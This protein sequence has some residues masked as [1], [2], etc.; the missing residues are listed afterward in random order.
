MSFCA[1]YSL[2]SFP[3]PSDVVQRP[4]PQAVRLRRS[5]SRGAAPGSGPAK[6]VPV[7]LREGGRS[8]GA[9]G[10]STMDGD[11]RVETSVIR[12]T[13]LSTD[14]R[15]ADLHDLFNPFGQIQ[16]VYLARDNQTH[17]ARGF[18]FVHFYKREDAERA[19]KGLEG[20]RYDH[21]VLHLEWA[22]YVVFILF[23]Y[24]FVVTSF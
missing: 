14:A 6:Y 4:R 2:L 8:A 15:E 10:G 24:C 12:V 7:H 18:A 11:R 16:R 22:R 23:Y 13:N 21:L 1:D 17:Q 9:G 20:Y 5:R 3:F 19:M